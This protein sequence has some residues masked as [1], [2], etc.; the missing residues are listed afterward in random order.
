MKEIIDIEKLII[1]EVPKDYIECSICGKYFPKESYCREGES[2]LSRTN[3][4]SCYHSKMDDMRNLEE[5][6]KKIKNSTKY[7]SVQTNWIKK[8]Q[9]YGNSISVGEMIE[10]LQKL[11]PTDRI[12]IGQD[13]YYAEGNFAE[14]YI[15]EDFEYADNNIYFYKIGH[16]SQNY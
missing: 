5:E 15:P 11:S 9:F 10:A 8:K 2:Y 4:S 3:C 1:I 13:G 6:V 16:S 12:F 14:I 7:K